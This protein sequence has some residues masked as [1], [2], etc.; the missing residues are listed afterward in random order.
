M[1][2]IIGGPKGMLA[3]LSNYWGPVGECLSGSYQ[4]AVLSVSC[5]PPFSVRVS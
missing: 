2:G 4:E 3:P 1:G 5:L